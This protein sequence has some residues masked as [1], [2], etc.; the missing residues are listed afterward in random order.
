MQTAVGLIRCAAGARQLPRHAGS[1]WRM[2]QHGSNWAYPVRFSRA[3]TSN[4]NS[5]KWACNG[6][7]HFPPLGGI[8]LAQPVEQAPQPIAGH[9]QGYTA[10][11]IQTMSCKHPFGSCITT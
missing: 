10:L 4:I 1:E 2:K 3:S 7:S 5:Q 6:A 9:L 11:S 8:C